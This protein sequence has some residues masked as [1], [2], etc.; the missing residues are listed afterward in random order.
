MSTTPTLGRPGTTPSGPPPP[1]RV[2]VESVTGSRLV[3]LLVAAVLLSILTSLLVT[4]AVSDPT[5]EP[6]D[7]AAAPVAADADTGGDDDTATAAAPTT[8]DRI[9]ADPTQVGTPVG[10]RAPRVVEIELTTSEKEGQLADGTTYTYWTFDDQVPGPMLRVR[11]GDTVDLTLSNAADSANIHSIDLHAVTGPGGGAKALQ[12]PPGESR[13]I[14]FRAL[15]PG[16]YVYHCATPH[17]PTHIANGMYGLIVVEPEG[18][19][20][21]V[22]RELYVMQGEVYTAEGRGATG[23]NTYDGEAMTDEDATYVVFNGQANALTGDHAMQAEVGETIRLFVGNGGPNLSSSF[24]VIGEIFDRAR[25]DGGSLVNEDVQ[26]TTIPAGGATWVEFT[27]EVPGDFLLVDHA[28]TRTIDKGAL[29][30]LH[31]TGDDDPSV[32][33]AHDG[34]EGEGGDT[35]EPS[36]EPAAETP[37]SD[38]TVAVS[39]TEFTFGRDTYTVPAGEVTFEVTN[40]GA[41]PHQFAIGEPGNRDAHLADTGILDAGATQTVTVDLE[42]GTWEIA[43]FIPGHYESGMT[44]TLVVE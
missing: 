42:P 40:D 39:M 34:L 43:C 4:G 36:E 35:T 27:L 20:D 31:V 32:F 37:A 5:E 8:A 9:A 28:I 21:P 7:T 25:V 18:G 16:V 14:T 11:Q 13:S 33:E 41:A 30:I 12:V 23:L 6:P 22:D 2:E 44:A 15:N 1:T 24:H 38:G 19:L 17:I 3:A 10:A 29:A 26:T